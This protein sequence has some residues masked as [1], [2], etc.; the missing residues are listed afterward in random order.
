[1]VKRNMQKNRPLAILL[2]RPKYS[3]LM[4]GFFIS[5]FLRRR[6]PVCASLTMGRNGIDDLLWGW[7][8]AVDFLSPWSLSSLIA[9]RAERS[10]QN[11]CEFDEGAI[12]SECRSLINGFIKAGRGF[13]E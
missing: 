12:T 10:D 13:A 1:M 6:T 3:G 7:N 2:T 5:K 9:H 4:R 11:F 8:Q